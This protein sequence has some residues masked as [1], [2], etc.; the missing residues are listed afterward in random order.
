MQRV[1]STDL[2]EP[3]GDRDA[4]HCTCDHTVPS[5]L[6]QTI[7]AD[8]RSEQPRELRPR[9]TGRFNAKVPPRLTSPDKPK[10]SP[11]DRHKFQAHFFDHA[12][13]FV[14]S[15]INEISAGFGMLP[16]CK[17]LTN[18]PY[19]APDAASSFHDGD[20]TAV[21]MQRPGGGQTRQPRTGDQHRWS[22]CWRHRVTIR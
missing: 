17:S 11:Q 6:D 9:L 2:N 21:P 18:G 7:L 10:S 3:L 14:L 15:L 22:G 13:Y 5:A 20:A 8:I 16:V 1:V 12:P 19:S 4:C